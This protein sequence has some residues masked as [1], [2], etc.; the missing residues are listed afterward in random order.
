MYQGHRPRVSNSQ[1]YSTQCT[2][3]THRVLLLRLVASYM[4][5]G[6]W[7]KQSLLHSNKGF[8][9]IP[10][11]D[12]SVKVSQL[13]HWNL[14]MS[15]M[16]SGSNLAI[17]SIPKAR[18][19]SRSSLDILATDY[20]R[21]SYQFLRIVA[22]PVWNPTTRFFLTWWMVHLVSFGLPR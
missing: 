13:W 8:K 2:L 20:S 11:S 15:P 6:E 4:H 1:T 18:Q 17:R 14:T 9:A 10:T 19:C 5:G 3:F 7:H 16:T 21:T 12:P 22:E